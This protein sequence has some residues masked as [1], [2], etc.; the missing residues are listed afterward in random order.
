M[1]TGRVDVAPVQASDAA[2]MGVSDAGADT[3]AGR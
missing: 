1:D 3:G 2:F